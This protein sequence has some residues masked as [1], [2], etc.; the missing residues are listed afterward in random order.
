VLDTAVLSIV[1][2]ASA[3]RAKSLQAALQD[4]QLSTEL[5]MAD[6]T[7]ADN[8]I[9]AF[10]KLELACD[11]YRQAG[12]SPSAVEAVESFAQILYFKDWPDE[13]GSWMRPLAHAMSKAVAEPACN[14]YISA[15]SWIGSKG[16]GSKGDVHRTLSLSF[17]EFSDDVLKNLREAEQAFSEVGRTL[18]FTL[19]I[20]AYR[21]SQRI[22]LHPIEAPAS[23]T[24]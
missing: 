12:D 14:F 16:D 6:S 20:R 15:H 9:V 7:T 5:A 21:D 22:R 11:A 8:I 13:I 23:T 2:E 4:E 18:A 24:V 10:A 17:Y 1:D 3:R 19:E